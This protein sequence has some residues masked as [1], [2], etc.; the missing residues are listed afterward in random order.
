MKFEQTIDEKLGELALLANFKNVVVVGLKRQEGIRQT[1]AMSARDG[2][3][4]DNSDGISNYINF[5]YGPT[6]GTI[7]TV[8]VEIEA[9]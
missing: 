1:L 2:R 8:I 5:D 9:T 4:G 7:V 6:V 3:I